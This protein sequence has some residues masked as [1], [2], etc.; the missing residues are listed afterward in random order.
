VADSNV[1]GHRSPCSR[2]SAAALAS[3]WLAIVVQAGSMSKPKRLAGRS[4]AVRSGR[5]GA[6]PRWSIKSG[7]RE[8]AMALLDRGSVQPASFSLSIIGYP[9]G[10]AGAGVARRPHPG[11]G[12]RPHRPA[13]V[14]FGCGYLVQLAT[15][16]RPQTF[17]GRLWLLTKEKP[18]CWTRRRAFTQVR[19][20][21]NIQLLSYSLVT[22]KYPTRNE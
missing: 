15:R 18:G 17:P 9:Q 8:V 2:C 4:G 12:A 10:P 13:A 22:H 11:R 14:G 1:V 7:E 20:G 6:Q 19:R 16:R 21:S 5:P 3:A